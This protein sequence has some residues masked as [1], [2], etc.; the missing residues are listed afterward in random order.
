[1]RQVKQFFHGPLIFHNNP[2]SVVR[3]RHRN[4][5]VA[6]QITRDSSGREHLLLNFF[7]QGQDPS[8]PIIREID[9]RREAVVDWSTQKKEVILDMSYDDMVDGTKQYSGEVWER[10]KR[11][12]R[13]LSGEP[14]P[15]S[16]APPP[17][18]P[19]RKQE[20]QEGGWTSGLMG[21]FAGL[22]AHGQDSS[23]ASEDGPT[24]QVYTDG[25]VHADLIMVGLHSLRHPG[26]ILTVRTE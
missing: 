5:R 25:E 21:M 22:K 20:K 17:P 16:K 12:F 2:P 4:D 3:P 8:K 11:L 26:P 19:E 6:S 10:C 14:L 9:S 1:M 13:F 24:G 15:S 23:N 7:I 18:P